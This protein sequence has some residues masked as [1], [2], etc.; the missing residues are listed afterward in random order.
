MK[1]DFASLKFNYFHTLIELKLASFKKV[2]ANAFLVPFSSEKFEDIPAN[3][4]IEKLKYNMKEILRKE[5]QKTT[6]N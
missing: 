2:K 4:V 1:N 5:I 6:E 3:Q